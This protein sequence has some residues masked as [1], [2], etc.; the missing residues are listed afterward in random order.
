MIEAQEF[1]NKTPFH[2]WKTF[3]DLNIF[4]KFSVSFTV[5]ETFNSHPDV[6]LFSCLKFN[7][8][9]CGFHSNV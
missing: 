1:Q 7:S 3:K 4:E 2:S 9:I 6:S 8:V 5:L